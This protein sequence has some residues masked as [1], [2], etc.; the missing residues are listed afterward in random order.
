[1]YLMT[2]TRPDISYTTGLLAR[3]MSNPGVEHFQALD[4]LWNYLSAHS[5][6]GITF[7]LNKSIYAEN[8]PNTT[9]D[10]REFSNNSKNDQNHARPTFETS[11]PAKNESNPA[12]SEKINDIGAA[13]PMKDPNTV[14]GHCDADWGGDLDNRRSTTGLIFQFRGGA[15]SWASKLQKTVA[16]SSCEAEYMA[17]KE[18]V[19]E[20]IWIRQLLGELT[21][22]LPGQIQRFN[23]QDIFIDS[24]SAIQLA[25]NPGTH[26]RTKHID[27]QYHFTREN[28]K[29]GL[30]RLFYAPIK[31]HLADGLTKAVDITKIQHLKRQLGLRDPA[32]CRSRGVCQNESLCSIDSAQATARGVG[33]AA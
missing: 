2:K 3:F 17:L 28:V 27:I 26:A 31:T 32:I 16:L 14:I 20:Q 6:L 29:N 9:R 18:A 21:S 4:K 13:R 33:R 12:I 15:I 24:A 8:G 30:T 11:G 23:V 22:K 5:A 19:K 10:R 25:K 1:M 7:G